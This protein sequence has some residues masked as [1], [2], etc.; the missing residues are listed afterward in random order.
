MIA[1]FLRLFSFP[2][3]LPI[4]SSFLF[5]VL[6]ALISIITENRRSTQNLVPLEK[7]QVLLLKYHI[8]IV[9]SLLSKRSTQLLNYLNNHHRPDKLM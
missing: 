1:V 3:P 7:I 8:D 2:I 5:I 6:T 4:S 9:R